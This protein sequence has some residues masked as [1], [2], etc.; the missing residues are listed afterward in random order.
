MAE[1][2]RKRCDEWRAES[3]GDGGPDEKKGEDD[4]LPL[5]LRGVRARATRMAEREKRR[6]GWMD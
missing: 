2:G 3:D 6:D 5:L 1:K 4:P